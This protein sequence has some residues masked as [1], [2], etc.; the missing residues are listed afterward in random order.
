MACAFARESEAA[1]SEFAN[2]VR[3]YATARASAATGA[4]LASADRAFDRASV[5]SGADEDVADRVPVRMRDED[6][7]EDD[8]ADLVLAR[9]EVACGVVLDPV[10]LVM[11]RAIVWAVVA[12]ARASFPLERTSEAMA[13]DDAALDNAVAR[14]SVATA[15]DAAARGRPRLLVTAAILEA[16]IVSALASLRTRV[17]TGLEAALALWLVECDP[18]EL[19]TVPRDAITDMPVLDSALAVCL[20]SAAAKVAEFKRDL[21]VRRTRALVGDVEALALCKNSVYS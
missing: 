11:A 16:E 3:A 14:T 9:L 13:E 17:P 4:L 19:K 1:P 5:E 15:E 18:P 7:A 6:V 20:T 10:L 12:V 21:P 8:V 2:S